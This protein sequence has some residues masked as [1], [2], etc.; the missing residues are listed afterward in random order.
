MKVLNIVNV[1]MFL[2]FLYNCLYVNVFFLFFIDY[3]FCVYDLFL[4]IKCEI[5][6]S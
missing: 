1:C 5:R 3:G 4:E 2:W 6:V